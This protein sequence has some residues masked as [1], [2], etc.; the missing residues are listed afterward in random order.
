MHTLLLGLA[1]I[2]AA[3][4]KKDPPK[5]YPPTI[6]GEWVPTM[7]VVG[8]MKDDIPAGST[9]T[10]TKE[11]KAIMK[12]GKDAKP[13]EMQFTFDPKQDP[14]HI[15]ISEPGMGNLNMLGIYKLEGD[16]LTICLAFGKDRPTVF[17]SPPKSDFILITLRRPAKD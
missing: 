5:K 4:A 12:E 8:G 16:S 9:M 17:A 6:L 10:L 3:P 14:P 7:I 11:G 1:I 2:V 13:E 15:T